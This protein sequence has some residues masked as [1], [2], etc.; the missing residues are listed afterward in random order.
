MKKYLLLII[1]L[2]LVL[3]LG[4]ALASCGEEPTACTEH[5]DADGNGKCD[6]CDA[7]V[8]PEGNGGGDNTG[9]DLVLVTDS[10]TGFAVVCTDSV[11]DKA[12]GYVI[13]FMNTLNRYYLD[14][15]NLK[16][17]YDAPGFDDAIEIIFGSAKY[18]GDAL[19]KDEHYLGYKGFSIELIGNKLFVLGGG[20]KGYQ[21][22]IKYLE[23][24]LFDLESYG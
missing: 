14:D 11:S 10:V 23:D 1:S 17:N 5:T 7:A 12:T 9:D 3:T 15:S 4:I 8:E 21:E 20:D 18:R 19:T 6:T 22:A 24:T 2:L 13:D 16:Q